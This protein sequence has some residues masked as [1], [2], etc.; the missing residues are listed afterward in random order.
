MGIHTNV[1][2]GN[3]LI[4]LHVGGIHEFPPN[5][6]HI[7]KAGLPTGDYHQ[8]IIV[9]NFEKW[10]A[11]K[12]IPKFPPQ[13]EIVLDNPPYYCLQADKPLSFYTFKADMI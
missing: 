8:H 1:Y 6:Q 4:M 7:F 3:R 10:V 13:A 11:K 2:S 5:A 9:T 12:S